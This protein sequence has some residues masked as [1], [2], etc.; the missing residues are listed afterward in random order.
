MTKRD[1]LYERCRREYVIIGKP[2][3]TVAKLMGI[4]ERTLHTWATDNK[5]G[6]GTWDEQRAGLM[7][8]ESTL[9]NELILTAA[10]CLRELREDMSEGRLDS[11]QVSNVEKFV[12]AAV[13]ALEYHRKSPPPTQE[14]LTK[15]QVREK[16]QGDLRRKLGLTGG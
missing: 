4:S 6:K 2:R 8:G 10:I 13:K 5:D 15:D 11:K 9:H 1:D 14:Q 7:D 3:S 12:K 16:L